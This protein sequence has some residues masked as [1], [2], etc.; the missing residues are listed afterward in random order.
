M[1]VPV[2]M[3]VVVPQP[4]LRTGLRFKAEKYSAMANPGRN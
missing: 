3:E 1:P 2:E 4:P